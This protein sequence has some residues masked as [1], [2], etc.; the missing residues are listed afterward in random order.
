MGRQ[1][2]FL[3]LAAGVLNALSGLQPS[4]LGSLG[5]SGDPKSHWQMAMAMATI[6]Q[7]LDGLTRGFC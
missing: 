7:F 1:M 2:K 5:A 6:D 3:A 4:L